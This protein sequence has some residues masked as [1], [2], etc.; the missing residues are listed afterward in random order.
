[1][2]IT[3]LSESKTARNVLW[4]IGISI[5]LLLVFKAGI[6]VGFKKAEFSYRLGE[7][8]Y[9]GF[10]GPRQGFP[11]DLKENDFLMSHGTF[12]S[13][14]SVSSSSLIV[15]DRNKAERVIILS[16]KT[17]IVKFRDTIKPENL[18]PN[19]QLVVVG[20]PNASGEIEAKLIRVLPPAPLFEKRLP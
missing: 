7:R 14:I 6:S 20:S 15:Q 8:Y 10:T 12:G 4:I 16:D 5:I 1:M 2:N 18:K 19:D 9:R 11:A 13:V 3:Q 17:A